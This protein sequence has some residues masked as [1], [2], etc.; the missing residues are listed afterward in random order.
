MLPLVIHEERREGRARD[1]L[2]NGDEALADEH[3]GHRVGAHAVAATQRAAWEAL[4]RADG[5][6]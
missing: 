4:R 6:E 1:V 5:D 3:D 2:H